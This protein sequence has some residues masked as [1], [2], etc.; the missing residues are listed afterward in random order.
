M[1]VYARLKL[2]LAVLVYSITFSPSDISSLMSTALET[3]VE[4]RITGFPVIDDDWKLVSY[5][6]PFLVIQSVFHCMM[7]NSM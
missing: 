3:L 5:P 2:C 1:K 6:S 7:V 4:Y